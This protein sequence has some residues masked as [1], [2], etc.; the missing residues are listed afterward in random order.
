MLW[1]YLATIGALVAAI[2]A[3]LLGFFLL[4]FAVADLA[5]AKTVFVQLFA[6][7]QMGVGVGFLAVAVLCDLSRKLSA[8]I[9]EVKNAPRGEQR[10]RPP[11]PSA[12][13]VAPPAPLESLRTK[14]PTCGKVVKAG[15]DWAGRVGNCPSCGETIRFSRGG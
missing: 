2:F 15:A 8:L 14:C 9:M 6:M 11:A 5:Q 4:L 10:E 12:A 1:F 7:I 3:A 13:A